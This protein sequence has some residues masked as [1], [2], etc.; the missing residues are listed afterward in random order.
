M[1]K[2]CRFAVLT[3]ALAALLVGVSQSAAAAAP[4][5]GSTVSVRMASGDQAVAAYWTPE[6]MENAIDGDGLIAEAVKR[7]Q[8]IV[9]A[10]VPVTV[11]DPTS[12]PASDTPSIAPIA[13]IG[14]VFMTL[15][16]E[17]YV[18]SGNS[19]ASGNHDVVATA[20]HCVKDGTGSWVTNFE[21]VPAYDNGSAP[22]GKYAA[23]TV[24]TTTGWAN[25]GDL[26]YDTGFAV[27]NTLN[28]QHVN[29][30]AGAS[31]VAFNQARGS[32]FTLYGYPAAP[33]FNGETL[34]TCSGAARQDDQSSTDQGVSCN[35][36]GGSSGGPWFIGG[37]AGGQ[38]NSINSFGY[39]NV[40]NV[41]W[42]PYWGSDIQ[43][44]Y[45]DASAA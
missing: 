29:T 24:V 1:L 32:S 33:P 12:I 2:A 22:Y 35:M 40:A 39:D 18:C 23:R 21:F 38:Q 17:D 27:M 15:D 16:G 44:A 36:T 37:G 30:A 19:I 43:D 6:R 8:A 7:A 11:G 45:N 25:N 31:G 10:P 34:Q 26:N 42:G 4:A 3:V 41:M 13:H 9:T 14:K 20:G 5:S 28:G